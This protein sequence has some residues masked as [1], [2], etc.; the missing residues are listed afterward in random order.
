MS[1]NLMFLLPTTTGLIFLVVGFILFKFPPRNINSFYGYR[2][3]SSMKNQARWDFAQQYSSK[4]FMKL[5]LVLALMGLMGFV[6]QPTIITAKIICA[7]LIILS[8]IVLI[9]RVETAISSVFKTE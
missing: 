6:Y 7:I 2:T 5:G 3:R 8:V 9:V 1:T 4:E